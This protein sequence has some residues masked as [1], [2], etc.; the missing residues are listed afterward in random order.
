[1]CLAQSLSSGDLQ[2]VGKGE[3]KSQVWC[4]FPRDKIAQSVTKVQR[5]DSGMN[6]L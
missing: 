3:K 4:G 2:D 1:M 5:R 6:I